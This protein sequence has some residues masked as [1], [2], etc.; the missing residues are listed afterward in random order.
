MWLQVA[1]HAELFAAV[2]ESDLENYTMAAWA[3]LGLTLAIVLVLCLVASKLKNALAI[4]AMA[5]KPIAAMPALLL[6]PALSVPPFAVAPPH[7]GCSPVHPG[8]PLHTS[9]PPSHGSRLPH[10]AS[11]AASPA[12]GPPPYASKAATSCIQGCDPTHASR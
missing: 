7:P 9:R 2:A 4:C 5:T 6:L 8:L 1:S 11:D 10:H 3:C 12:S